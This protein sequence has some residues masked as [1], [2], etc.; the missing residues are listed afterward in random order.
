LS[1]VVAIDRSGKRLSKDE[2][3][4][5]L[6]RV[7]HREMERLDPTGKPDWQKLTE[8]EREFYRSCIDALLCTS[9][10]SIVSTKG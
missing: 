4:E 6:A 8:R 3:I 10:V 7:L 1:A 5:G 2:T 9:E